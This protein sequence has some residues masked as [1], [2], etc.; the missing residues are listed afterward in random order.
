MPSLKQFAALA[1]ILTLSAC[2]TE[3]VRKDVP[4]LIIDS[5]AESHAE[6]QDLVSNALDGR[7]VKLADTALTTESLLVIEPGRLMGRDLRRPQHFQ[8]VLDG[9]R[10]ILVHQ[11]SE[12]RYELVATSCAA[13]TYR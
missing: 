5:T 12:N 8:L 4:A 13:E 9:S 7:K 2:K 1:L 6:L 10:C 3:D 11:E